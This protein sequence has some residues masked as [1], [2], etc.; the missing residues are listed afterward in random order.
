MAKVTITATLNLRTNQAQ[1]L[2]KEALFESMQELFGIDIVTT[3]KELCPVLKEGTSERY[4]GELRDSIDSRITKVKNGAR[5]KVFTT[6]G[7]GGYVENGTV[8]MSAEP[9]IYPAFE[10][11]I[12]KLPILMKEAVD[13]LAT[14]KNG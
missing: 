14:D 13:N 3:A 10:S 7:Y 12:N 8:K 5:A 11:N 1:A 2:I 9:F 4:P 6:A